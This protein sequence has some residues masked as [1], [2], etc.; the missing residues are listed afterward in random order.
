MADYSQEHVEHHG[1]PHQ[2]SD[3]P[4]IEYREVHKAFDVPVLAGVS[5]TVRAGE[6]LALVGPSGT[7]KSV[8]LKTTIGLIIPDAGDIV[9]DGQSVVGADAQGLEEIRLKARY[10]FQGAALF[11]SLT[12]YENIALGIDEATTK[13]L[14]RKEVLRRVVASIEDVNLDPHVVL[15]KL[16]S[17]LSGGMR[18]RVGLARGIV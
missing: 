8:L 4:M 7:G 3:R 14:G 18:K 10:V 6:T 13:K 16:P 2:V 15:N 11:D 1:P 9:V 12:V 17:E 5:L